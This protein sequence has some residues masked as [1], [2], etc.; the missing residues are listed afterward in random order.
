MRNLLHKKDRQDADNH[1]SIISNAV[2]VVITVFFFGTIDI[3]K[4]KI[5]HTMY[6]KE[7]I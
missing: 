4:K 6:K 1:E 3:K 2:T 7:K 5:I